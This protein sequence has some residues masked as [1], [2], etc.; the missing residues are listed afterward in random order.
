LSRKEA[1]SSSTSSTLGISDYQLSKAIPEKLKSALPSV[2][3]VEE[4]LA[5][6]LDK[7]PQ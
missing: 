3:E 5:S 2:E 7:D 6:F 1:S 4:E